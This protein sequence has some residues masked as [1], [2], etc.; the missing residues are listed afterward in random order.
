MCISLPQASSSNTAHPGSCTA[1]GVEIITMFNNKWYAIRTEV[2]EAKFDSVQELLSHHSL[3]M[4][5]GRR[6]LKDEFFDAIGM[7]KLG[8]KRMLNKFIV[9]HT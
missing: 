4:P 9:A 2:L 1:E 6:C 7:T 5:D 8:H 3:Q